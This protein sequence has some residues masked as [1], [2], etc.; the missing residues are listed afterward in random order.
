MIVDSLENTLSL[1]CDTI[2]CLRDS[3]NMYGFQLGVIEDNNKALKEANKYYMNTNKKL[4][5]TNKNLS[6]KTE[7]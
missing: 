6:N 1:K 2:K 4:V 5:D 7:E 3:I